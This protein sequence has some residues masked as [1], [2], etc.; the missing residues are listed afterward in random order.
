LN[1]YLIKLIAASD[2]KEPRL[3]KLIEANEIF[4]KLYTNPDF[5]NL[6][7]VTDD[8]KTKIAAINSNF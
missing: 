7:E 2:K 8:V 6:T 5:L 4:D 1:F 3:E